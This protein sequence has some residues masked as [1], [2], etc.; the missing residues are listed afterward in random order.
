MIP[1]ISST[2]SKIGREE[3]KWQELISHFRAVQ[4][5]HEKARRQAMGADPSAPF[6]E[7]S[8]LEERERMNDNTPSM[9]PNGSTQALPA[10][11]GA[12]M[13]RKGDASGMGS[14][15][16]PV[17]AGRIGALSPL[18]PRAR[19]TGLASAMGRV[20]GAV[21][22]SSPNANQEGKGRRAPS[23]NHKA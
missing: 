22:P 12:I 6:A 2:R 21:R 4:A 23:L 14:V 13:R 5:K 19:A 9:S 18:N 11:R 10:T 16:P 3:I 17:S 1:S 7:F 15:S 8:S 20:A